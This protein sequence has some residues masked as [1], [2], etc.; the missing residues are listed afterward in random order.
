MKHKRWAQKHRKERHEYNIQWMRNHRMLIKHHNMLIKLAEALQ[1]I[2][3]LVT[4]VINEN[5]I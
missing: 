5:F 4:E 2:H 1:E 3:S